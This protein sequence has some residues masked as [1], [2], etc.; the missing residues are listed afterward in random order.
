MN[1]P[2][3]KSYDRT[4][5]DRWYRA[6]DAPRGQEEL[7]RQVALA[8]AATESV[9]DRPLQ[10]VLDIGCGEGRWQPALNLLR[11]EAS[12]LGID[13]SPYAVER[14]GASRNLLSGSLETLDSFAFEEPFD[15][16]VCSDVLHYVDSEAVLRSLDVLADLVGGVALLEI[17]TAD[18][19]VEGDREDFQ[20]RPAA[21]YRRA[22]EAAGLVPI[23]L[24]LYVHRDV[25]EDL[26][27]LDLPG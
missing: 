8:V 5:F 10:S 16:V 21:W 3:A 4:Y 13:P 17:F 24:Q 7:S 23:G 27:A 25:A 2:S 18:D 26:D 15:L 6:A 1:A 9:L 14:F 11:P 12:Y 20:E 19:P 22:F